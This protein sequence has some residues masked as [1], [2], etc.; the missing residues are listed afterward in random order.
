VATVCQEHWG[1]IPCKLSNMVRGCPTTKC[2]VCIMKPKTVF[3]VYLDHNWKSSAVAEMGDRLATVD[4]DRKVGEGLLCP[5]FYE[6]L[7]SN[8]TQCR[9]SRGLPPY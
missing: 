3:S 4:I 9:L 8:L 7:G 6:E 5:F 2:F 1:L